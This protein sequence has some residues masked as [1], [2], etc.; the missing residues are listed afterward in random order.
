MRPRVVVIENRPPRKGCFYWLCATIVCV[1]I[2]FLYFRL[3]GGCQT[4]G[5]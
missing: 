3:M 5:M 4:I 1:A 2:V